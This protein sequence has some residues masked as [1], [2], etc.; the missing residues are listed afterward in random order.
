M[1]Q[2]LNV[3]LKIIHKIFIVTW[4]LVLQF[5][6]GKKKEIFLNEPCVDDKFLEGSY[7]K[8]IEGSDVSINND[9]VISSEFE[10][11][12]KK[13]K[14]EQFAKKILEDWFFSNKEY[15]YASK[16]DIVELI[17]K[18]HLDEKSIRRWLYNKRYRTQT[19]QRKGFSE[20]DKKVLLEF[21]HNQNNHPGPA[22]LELLGK[23]LQKDE[24]KIR[25]WF[26]IMRHRKKNQN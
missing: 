8:I 21:F 15:P 9:N 6:I 22:D 18:T 25:S 17:S 13:E 26:N 1:S 4:W 5:F 3:L 16:A 11:S 20:I 12:P 24:K 10:V 14:I 2:N 19:H 7:N 23:I